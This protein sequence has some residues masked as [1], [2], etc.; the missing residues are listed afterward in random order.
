MAFSLSSLPPKLEERVSA[1]T[2]AARCVARMLRNVLPVVEVSVCLSSLCAKVDE[3]AAEEEVVYRGDG[4]GVAHECGRVTAE[5]KGH[6]SRDTVLRMCISPK[7]LQSIQ[8]AQSCRQSGRRN[9]IS[10]SF[11]VSMTAARGIPKFDAGPQKS[12]QSN[13]C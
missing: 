9:Y 2:H 11:C 10:G 6:G 4:H 13:S 3:V 7:L 8:L 5:G 12:V 1:L